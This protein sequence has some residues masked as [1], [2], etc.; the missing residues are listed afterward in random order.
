MLS[1]PAIASS[2]VLAAALVNINTADKT[3]IMTLNGLGGTG[4]KAQ[5][6]IDY[7]TKNGPFLTIEDIMNVSGIGT[8]TFAKIKDYITVGD[9][10]PQTTNTAA[11]DPN[12][13]AATT[14]I[15][16][17]TLTQNQTSSQ[18]VSNS[19]TDQ[20]ET[21]PAAPTLT[22]K[23]TADISSVVGV[24]SNFSAVVLGEKGEPIS[25]AR[26][27][28]NFGDGMT[29]QGLKVF[30]VFS[31]PGR[32]VV[33]A[34]SAYNYSEGMSQVV[35]DVIAGAIS[36]IVAADGSLTIKNDASVAVDMGLWTLREGQ[37]SFTLPA[38]TVSAPGGSIRLSADTLGFFGSAKTEFFYP[39]GAYAMSA[40]NEIPPV[41]I[42][43]VQNSTPKVTAKTPKQKA[44][45]TAT[46]S[47]MSAV[48]DAGAGDPLPL[49]ASLAALGGLMALGVL[50]VRY[51]GSAKV[52][53]VTGAPE[54][55]F[56]I[57]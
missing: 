41:S 3:T 23:L 51:A 27:V 53:A 47:Q 45:A 28:W 9:A 57:E 42:V 6:V 11:A 22:V 46:S 50:G 16:S 15:T 49:Y 54:D 31:Y 8:A 38:H 43:A 24:G 18:T 48:A 32:Y 39:N 1:V 19:N 34:T 5:A 35:V 36:L 7:R 25:D 56:E 40:T 29:A 21:T 44:V 52:L 14:T 17:D 4:V 13:G 30:H 26:V 2:V 12:A 55:E 10:A 20:T 37:K 33:S